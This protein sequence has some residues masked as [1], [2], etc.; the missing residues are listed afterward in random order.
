MAGACGTQM[1]GPL[2]PFAAGFGGRSL[3]RATRR[4]GYGS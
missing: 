3:P 1:D 4:S 2:A